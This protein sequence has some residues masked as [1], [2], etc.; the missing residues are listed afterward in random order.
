MCSETDKPATGESGCVASNDAKELAL[1]RELRDELS[2]YSTGMA[3]MAE[4][5]PQRIIG[6]LEKARKGE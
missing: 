4:E 3:F 5:G 6:E 1:L 2:C